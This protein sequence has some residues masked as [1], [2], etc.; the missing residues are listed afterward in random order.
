[1]LKPGASRLRAAPRSRRSMAS[2][3]CR[4]TASGLKELLQRLVRRLDEIR[5]PA[6]FPQA[7]LAQLDGHL[8]ALGDQRD[9][10]DDRGSIHLAAAE[11]HHRQA[12]GRHDD[13]GA[14]VEQDAALAF[15]KGLE[16]SKSVL[17]GKGV[18]EVLHARIDRAHADHALLQAV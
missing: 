10:V 14:G 1:M 11:Q 6:D 5:A 17:A 9:A 2:R 16:L 18:D 8:G 3:Y 7:E 12:A 4:T 13:V 15:P